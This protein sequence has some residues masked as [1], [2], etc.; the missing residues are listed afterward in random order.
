MVQGIRGSISRR[1]GRHNCRSTIQMALRPTQTSIQLISE[2]LLLSLLKRRAR[3]AEASPQSSFESQSKSSHTS[4][5]SDVFTA[6]CKAENKENSAN[7]IFSHLKNSDTIILQFEVLFYIFLIKLHSLLCSPPLFY[8]YCTKKTTST[9]PV[10]MR[11][12]TNQIMK[13]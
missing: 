9:L 3:D 5:H 11:L 12:Q 10:C 13:L 7:L 1:T 2:A 6:W 4:L 8:F